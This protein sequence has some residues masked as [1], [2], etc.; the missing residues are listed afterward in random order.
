MGENM[1][2]RNRG[3]AFDYCRNFIHGL[4]R[5]GMPQMGFI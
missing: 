3:R 2:D 1:A 5:Q 4:M